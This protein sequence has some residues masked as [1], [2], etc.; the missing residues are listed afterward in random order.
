MVRE[1]GRP[2]VHGCGTN[3]GYNRHRYRNEQPCAECKEAKS[4][5]NQARST[6]RNLAMNKCGTDRGYHQHRRRNEQ[7]CPACKEA[8]A[9]YQIGRYRATHVPRAKQPAPIYPQDVPLPDMP[10]PEQPQGLGPPGLQPVHAGCRR[11]HLPGL[12]CWK[13]TYAQDLSRLVFARHGDTCWLCGLPGADTCDHMQSRA[14]GGDDS[15]LNMRPAHQFCNS[16][17][18]AGAL[19]PTPQEYKGRHRAAD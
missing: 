14:L 6:T 12:P 5:Y 7:P 10:Q 17:R 11:R 16:G 8:H 18:G 3:A 1:M 15:L 9:A 2:R 13:G 4:A 19:R